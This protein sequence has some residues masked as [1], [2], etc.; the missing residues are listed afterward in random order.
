MRLRR[1]RHRLVRPGP[2]AGTVRFILIAGVF[3]LIGHSAQA[4]PVTLGGDMLQRAVAGKTVHLDTPLGVAIPITFHANGTMSG[5]AGVLEYF[6]GAEADRGRW[7]VADGKLCQKWFKW[8][9]AQPSCMRL[10]QDGDRIFWRRDDG[11]NGTARIVAGLPLGAEGKPRA[12]GGPI[13]LP[14]ATEP[15]K[16]VTKAALPATKSSAPS[17]K[18]PEHRWPAPPTRETEATASARVHFESAGSIDWCRSANDPTKTAA[19]TVAIQ[20]AAGGGLHEPTNACFAVQPA[21]QDVARLGLSPGCN[22]EFDA[23]LPLCSRHIEGANRSGRAAAI[24][25]IPMPRP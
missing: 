12:L 8:L 10:Q 2:T 17:A 4:E 18:G 16:I 19:H 9:D 6:L 13:P 5:K 24:R 7:W 14:Q 22:A 20:V 25:A 21:L 3:A 11:V 15:A 1:A 23:K